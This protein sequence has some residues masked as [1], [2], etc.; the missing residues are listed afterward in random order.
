MSRRS[1]IGDKLSKAIWPTVIARLNLM[2]IIVLL[3][4]ISNHQKRKEAPTILSIVDEDM[5]EFVVVVMPK[6][7]T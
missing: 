1:S 4:R 2:M 5:M 7:I 6:A 3:Q